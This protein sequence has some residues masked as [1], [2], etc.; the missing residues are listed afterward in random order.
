MASCVRRRVGG[1]SSF[2]GS[3]QTSPKGLTAPRSARSRPS[4]VQPD[5]GKSLAHSRHRYSAAVT[6]LTG[7]IASLDYVA[8]QGPELLSYDDVATRISGV[9]GRNPSPTTRS[10]STSWW[11]DILG[12]DSTQPARSDAFLDGSHHRRWRRESN[13]H[14]NCPHNFVAEPPVTFDQFVTQNA[15]LWVQPWGSVSGRSNLLVGLESTVASITLMRG[16]G[17]RARVASVFGRSLSRPS[18]AII[19]CMD[20]SSW[21]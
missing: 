17:W 15:S 19:Y 7:D 2:I 20:L 4:T 5:A 8:V 14:R 13:H 1:S 6:A 21:R 12:M 11:L 3:F 16:A 10:P 9:I 18:D